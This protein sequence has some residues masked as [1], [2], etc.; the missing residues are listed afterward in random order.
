MCPPMVSPAPE[1]AD[2]ALILAAWPEMP[3]PVKAGIVALVKAA[4]G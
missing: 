4:R 2:L 1:D 3:E